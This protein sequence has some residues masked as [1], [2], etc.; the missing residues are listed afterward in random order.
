MSKDDKDI[1][2]NAKTLS[3]RVDGK[4]ITVE[5]GNKIPA[6][7]LGTAQGQGL[8]GTKGDLAHAQRKLQ[9]KSAMVNTDKLPTTQEGLDALIEASVSKAL[10]KAQQQAPQSGQKK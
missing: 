10:K 2:V 3:K 8:A 9:G 5:R 1:L 7:L 4:L 6:E